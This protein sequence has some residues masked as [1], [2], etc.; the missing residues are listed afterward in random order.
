MAAGS[1]MSRLKDL[2]SGHQCWPPVPVVTGS[3]NVYV[4]KIL[5][6]KEGDTT[7]IHVCGNNP[8]H[9]DTCV[10]GSIRVRVNKKGAMRIGD[11]LSFGAV[12]T[13]GSHTVLAGG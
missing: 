11:L 12:M 13:E 8:P 6:I 10:K 5:A 9:A 2:E 7:A 1:G 4:N 3:P